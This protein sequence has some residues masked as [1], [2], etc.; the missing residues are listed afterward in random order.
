M[1]CDHY[2]PRKFNAY[3]I[4]EQ[5]V[6]SYKWYFLCSIATAGAEGLSNAETIGISSVVGGLLGALIIGASVS[7]PHTSELAG[8]FSICMVRT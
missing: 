1:E 3:N 5:D 2:G 6:S 7:E 8:G 4:R